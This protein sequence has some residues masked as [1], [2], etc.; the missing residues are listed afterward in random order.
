M[1]LQYVDNQYFAP[2]RLCV[3]FKIKRT[4]VIINGK[5]IN[6]YWFK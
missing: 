6:N 5:K 1:F 3:F 4:I 2:S